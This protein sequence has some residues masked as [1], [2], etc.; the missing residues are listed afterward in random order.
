MRVFDAMRHG[1]GERVEPS[2]E[3]RSRDGGRRLA[4]A[5]GLGFI[6]T[7][8]PAMGSVPEP[9]GT[10][11]SFERI[12]AH[13]GE[14]VNGQLTAT[15]LWAIALMVFLVFL[16]SFYAVLRSAEEGN[17]TLSLTALGSGVV[18]ITVMIVAQAATGATAIVASEGVDPAIVRGLDETAHMIAHLFGIPLGAFLLAASAVSLAHRVTWRWLGVVGIAAGFAVI[19]GTAGIFRPESVIHDLGVL[20]LLLFV[21]WTLGTSISLMRI[22]RRANREAVQPVI[23]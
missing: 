16:G 15:F 9:P 17:G 14:N 12:A 5:A 3:T 18:A 19:V 8:V 6:V 4:S 23:A 13:Y 22:Q 11:A 20:G 7:L 10:G 21:V 2:T 1:R